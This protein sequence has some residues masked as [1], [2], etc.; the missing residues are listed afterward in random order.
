MCGIQEA[1]DDLLKGKKILNRTIIEIIEFEE[2]DVERTSSQKSFL[3]IQVKKDCEKG[4]LC[5][6]TA[7]AFNGILN[8]MVGKYEPPKPK[9][10]IVK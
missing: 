5:D 10:S 9:L 1:K 8:N 2:D 3:A 4:S 6:A 7:D